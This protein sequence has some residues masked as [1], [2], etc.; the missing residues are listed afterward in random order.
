MV[1]IPITDSIF[2]YDFLVSR[3]QQASSEEGLWEV[4][5]RDAQII[6]RAVDRAA[7]MI[8]HGL[9]IQVDPIQFSNYIARLNQLLQENQEATFSILESGENGT[10]LD[11]RVM[12]RQQEL[13]EILQKILKK[14]PIL[15]QT[16]TPI[17]PAL[18][19]S[20][21][22]GLLGPEGIDM[23]AFLI[24]F[25]SCFSILN[26]ALSSEKSQESELLTFG[27]LS[28]IFSVILFKIYRDYDSHRC[29][30]E[31]THITEASKAKP[32]R[33]LILVAEDVFAD[34]TLMFPRSELT[35]LRKLAQTHSITYI[36]VSGT[37]NYC[38][39]PKHEHYDE[40]E[41][42]AH[43]NPDH[44][45]FGSYL[46]NKGNL[47]EWKRMG[48]AIRPGGKLTFYGCNAGQGM[49]N[50]AQK[51]SFLAPHATIYASEE[52][53]YMHDHYRKDAKGNPDFQNENG[54]DVLRIYKNGELQVR[55]PRVCMTIEH[56]SLL[57][58]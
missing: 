42:H 43:S 44:I 45:A 52:Y 36:V 2:D 14:T 21:L 1:S 37:Q 26:V 50:I 23:G 5:V 30:R 58:P 16:F 35:R 24:F 51:V 56:V 28:F 27:I 7:L 33:V 12:C 41:I 48:N 29:A 47:A 34:Y 19:T 6:Q 20:R 8:D 31:I 38:P 11:Q 49:N 9:K 46:I 32:N 39:I 13:S 40:V 17:S 55:E 18:A 3:P 10:V 54:L 22:E 57:T 15:S 4:R 53:V 25:G